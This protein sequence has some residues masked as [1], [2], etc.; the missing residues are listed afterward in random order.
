MILRLWCTWLLCDRTRIRITKSIYRIAF[1]ANCNKS[2]L[3]VIRVRFIFNL[4]HRFSYILQRLCIQTKYTENVSF[5]FIETNVDIAVDVQ[6]PA[7]GK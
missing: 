7:C 6:T 5:G 3:N 1:I 4:Y 2:N